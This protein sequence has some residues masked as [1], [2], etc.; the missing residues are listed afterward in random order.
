MNTVY[1]S[2]GIAFL[3]TS[4]ASGAVASLPDTDPRRR[5]FGRLHALST[6]LMLLTLL[7]GTG[8][9]WTEMK[10]HG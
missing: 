8:L 7:T 2:P 10:D 4:S 9:I 3:I 1:I 6:G 5:E